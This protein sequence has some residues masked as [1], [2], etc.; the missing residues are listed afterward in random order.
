MPARPFVRLKSPMPKTP[1]SE[2]IGDAADD[3]AERE[4][5]DRDV[6]A[7]QA[8][9][10]EAEQ[11]AGERGE[12]RG[13]RQDEQPVEVDAGLGLQQLGD[14]D[15]DVGGREEARAEPAHRVGADREERDVAEVEQAGE[16]DHDVQAE[17]H[18]DVDQRGRRVLDERAAGVV[19]ERQQDRDRR[20][21]RRRRSCSSWNRPTL[22]GS[23]M[24]RGAGGAGGAH[25]ASL[26]CSPSRPC[27]PEHEDQHEVAEHDRRRPL[28]ADPVV[29]DLLDD[30]DDQAAEDGALEVADAAH[31]RRGERDQAGGEA[32]E[33]P[34][35]GLVERVDQ[36]RRA[37]HQAAE[38]ERE[39]DRRVDVDAHQ[40]RGLR[41]LRGRAH[42]AADARAGDEVHEEEERA[43]RS[44]PGRGCRRA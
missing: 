22:R 7:A 38:Q 36:P 39:G 25:P 44:R 2:L 26:V 28:R 21:R 27:G 11:R 23:L 3:L 6:V 14:A 24:P 30:A 19:E 16:A 33:E 43:A 5:H 29:G 1:S 41:V 18:H 35:V 10:R 37:G 20:S 4:R 15:V 8:Q 13:D 40:A 34:H 42:G 9:R 17:R 12:D 31:D 32:G